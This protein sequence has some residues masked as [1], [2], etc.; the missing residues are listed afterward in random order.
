MVMILVFTDDGDTSI[1]S[2]S[3]IPDVTIAASSIS[4]VFRLTGA[5]QSVSPLQIL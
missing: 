3:C 4:N 2:D 5:D 1:A